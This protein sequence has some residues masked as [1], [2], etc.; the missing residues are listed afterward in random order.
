MNSSL[1][2]EIYRILFLESEEVYFLF[3]ETD[4]SI[5]DFNFSFSSLFQYDRY[6]SKKPGLGDI[7]KNFDDNHAIIKFIKSGEQAKYIE[8]VVV[9]TRYESELTLDFHIY[10]IH[11]YNS[12]RY[13]IHAIPDPEKKGALR[14]KYE[15]IS[16]ISHELIN[17]ISGIS[18][19]IELFKNKDFVNYDSESKNFIEII[20]KNLLRVKTLLDNLIQL[21]GRGKTAYLEVFSP[22]LVILE[23]INIHEILA[24]E[25]KLSI[26]KKLDFSLK[27]RGN[28][29]EFSQI[30]TNLMANAIKYT[31]HGEIELILSKKMETIC[32]LQIRDTGI[33]IESEY[34]SK[35][36]DQFFRI[37][38]PGVY[39]QSGV[40]IGLWIVKNLTEKMKGSIEVESKV[41]EGTKFTLYFPLA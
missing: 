33:G 22:S 5:R 38:S 32:E 3:T 1:L 11:V 25:K 28:Q 8:N 19:I 4:W 16:N 21:D 30:L 41:G 31:Q 10:R 36:Y 7:L 14:L 15:Y 26:T 29:F 9:Q 27:I 23:T 40:G 17:P 37:P 39:Q 6:E 34:Q 2:K 20:R 18:T 12:Y 35:I 24:F 13:L